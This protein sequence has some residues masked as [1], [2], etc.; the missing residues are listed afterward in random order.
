[1]SQFHRFA[2]FSV[3]VILVI[4]LGGCGDTP[5]QKIAR[6]KIAMQRRLPDE[7]LKLVDSALRSQPDDIE[8]LR[9]KANAELA[10]GFFDQCTATLDRLSE[11]DANHK[12]T[13]TIALRCALGHIDHL[14][15]R[16]DV[17][18]NQQIAQK[19]DDAIARAR[20]EAG[21]F[22]KTKNE[23]SEASFIRAQTHWKNIEYLRAKAGRDDLQAQQSNTEPSAEDDEIKRQYE[24]LDN[25]LAN[26]IA[27]KTTDGHPHWDA[28]LLKLESLQARRRPA[29][30]WRLAGEVVLLGNLPATVAEQ[31][32]NAVLQS[33]DR[34]HVQRVEMA[35]H[36]QDAVNADGRKSIRWKLTG[37]KL[38]QAAEEWDRAEELLNQV[39]AEQPNEF[40]A[41]FRWAHNH[42]G[43][44]KFDEAI[45]QL[46]TLSTETKGSIALSMINSLRGRSLMRLGQNDEAKL[47]LR[48]AIDLNPKNAVAREAL[49]EL[50]AVEGALSAAQRDVDEFLNEHSGD[51]RA[52]R[53]SVRIAIANG[54]PLEVKAVMKHVTKLG[55]LG[56]EHLEVLADGYTY[57]QKFDQAAIHLRELARRHPKE[58]KWHMRLARAMLSQDRYLEVEQMLTRVHRN[59]SDA[60]SLNEIIGQLFAEFNP[61]RAIGLLEKVA[62]AEPDNIRARLLLAQVLASLSRTNDAIRR[63]DEVL[64]IDADHAD[65]HALA[66]RI[67]R[68]AGDAQRATHHLAKIDLKEIDAMYRAAVE[69]QRELNEG[70]DA[71]AVLVCQRGILA[72]NQDPMLRLLLIEIYHKRKEPDALER[73]M[74][75]L[76][77]SQPNNPFAYQ[78]LSQFYLDESR[79]LYGVSQLDQLKG[80]NEALANIAQANLLLKSDQPE[81][82]MMRL[83]TALKRRIQAKD[84]RAIEIANQVASLYVK[85]DKRHAA[86]AAYQKLIDADLTRNRARL[87]KIKVLLPVAKRDELIK[88]LNTLT[89]DI[90]STDRAEAQQI[91][92]LWTQLGQYERAMIILDRWLRADEAQPQ[93]HRWKGDLLLLARQ[94]TEAVRAYRRAVELAPAVMEYRWRLAGAQVADLDF[95]AAEMTYRQIA[96]TDQASLLRAQIA[97][98]R[99]LAGIGLN[100]RASEVLGQIRLADVAIDA[101]AYGEAMSLLGDDTVALMAL[102]TIKPDDAPYVTAQVLAAQLEQRQ[103]RTEA[104]QQRISRLV[105]APAHRDGAV[106]KILAIKRRG[107]NFAEI[108]GWCDNWLEV[109]ELP[110]MLRMRW[111]GVQIALRANEGKWNDVNR[112]LEL[113]RRLDSKNIRVRALH[114][115]LLMHLGKRTEAQ[116]LCR[117]FPQ[118][119]NDFDELITSALNMSGSGGFKSNTLGAALG[120]LARGSTQ[121]ARDITRKMRPTNLTYTDDLERMFDQMDQDT[122]S[123]LALALIA[124]EFKLPQLTTQMCQHVLDRNPHQIVAWQLMAR[125]LLAQ[126]KPTDALLA[127]LGNELPGTSLALH[128]TALHHDS[129]GKHEKAVTA[130]QALL[131]RQPNNGAVIYQLARGQRAAARFDQSIATF[132]KLQTDDAWKSVASN[133]LAFLLARHQPERLDEAHRLALRAYDAMPHEA[134]VLDTLGWIEHLRGENETALH[135]LRAA[136]ATMS[137][138]AQLHYH[139]ATVYRDRGN[140]QWAIAHMQEAL[141]GSLTEKAR[142][143]GQRMLA[144]LLNQP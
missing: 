40:E 24:L 33:G 118:T 82:A 2:Q 89:N 117:A 55:P 92:R 35:W 74:L 83:E 136:L 57:L 107:R 69:A 68:F 91:V 47:V 17:V 96:E 78:M 103:N 46:R 48:E 38:F 15:N 134:A 31:F 104:A 50:L 105:S 129:A 25:E 126:Q 10:L 106:E 110:T 127:T 22:E 95:P 4:A 101:L 139:I 8:A 119:E 130:W 52:A 115:A 9:I 124:L 70:R 113:M 14:I 142:Q 128:L 138:D 30:V 67:H 11:S 143:D 140:R 99:M 100:K 51:A 137:R 20:K 21:W 59:L 64:S 98:G 12:P 77:K 45:A 42:Y 71:E 76:V 112:T 58:L 39:L 135:H 121:A 111:M 88:Q 23:Q 125:A 109:T 90:G 102:D 116:E 32:V 56:D 63:I 72:G 94:T 19:V 44:R 120:T 37:V 123:R 16:S 34:S 133:D 144:K 41:R 141:A 87:E 3:V 18:D 84:R 75:A 13:H 60:P 7:A 27:I 28:H 73:Q 54:K 132:E 131:D 36:I 85:S 5:Q 49:L 43:R 26:A 114:I 93:V 65:A 79:V 61:A 81:S 97:L 53:V 80:F 122:A 108:A 1:M 6:A 62:A 86:A 29:A 66:F